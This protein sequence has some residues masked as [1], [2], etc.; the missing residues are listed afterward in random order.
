MTKNLKLIIKIVIVL[1][2]IALVGYGIFKLYHYAVGYAT[3]SITKGVA[4]G[5]QKGIVGG[6][7]K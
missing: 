7:F 4:K 6:I 3:R 1:A 5:V 2:V